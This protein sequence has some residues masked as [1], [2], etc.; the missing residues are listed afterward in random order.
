MNLRDH[1][2]KQFNS[3]TAQVGIIGLGYAGLPLAFAFAEAGFTTYGFDIDAN[4][5]QA[6]TRGKSYIGHLPAERIAKLVKCGS[7]RPVEG[8][9][10]LARCD[11][12]I[13]CVPTP[14][15]RFRAPDLTYVTNTTKVVTA[16]L[17]PGQLVSLESTTYPGTTEE[18]LAPI[19]QQSGLKVGTDFFLAFSPEREDPA[20]SDFT[21]RTIPKLVG[22]VTRDCSAVATAAYKAVV[23]EVVT[24]SSARV[25]EAAKLLENI[26]RCVNIALV[27]ELKVLLRRM[28]I[29]VWEVIRAASTKP[30][31]FSPFYPGPGM[32][33]HCIPIDPFYL[34][35][36]AR[37]YGMSARFIELA[38]QINT[39]IPTY[40][41]ERLSQ[42][43]NRQGK[44]LRGTK[45][46]LIGVAYKR[47]VDDVRESPAFAI[48]DALSAGL[49]EI[50]YHDPH[51][52]KLQ[53]RHLEH[54]MWSIE[55]TPEAVV[56][57]DAV[58]IVTD[59]Q[60]VDYAM[61]V[62]YAKLIV[63]TRN[64]TAPYRKP[65]DNVILA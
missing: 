3:R 61:L 11:A 50:S 4:K 56:A 28:D 46:L 48:M 21:T 44:P 60:A 26:Y 17:H 57:A 45:I 7:L 63:D 2:L 64:A 27:N 20:N 8:F 12:A 1:A 38:G 52:P 30:F 24:V 58:L 13:I 32:G 42:G 33:G 14:L 53:S 5:I 31:G 55:L 37:E 22:G 54:A 40:V 59:H 49:A 18:V 25:A 10:A 39:S 41:V 23:T 36:K 65:N 15:D 51:V 35:W 34:V 43:L 47:N 9:D 16:F 19:L 6:L 29:D 62:R